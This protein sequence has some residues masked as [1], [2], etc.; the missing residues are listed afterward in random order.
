MKYIAFDL[1]ASSGKMMLGEFDGEILKTEVLHRFPNQQISANGSLYWNFLGIYQHLTEGLQKGFQKAGGGIAGL[2]MDSFCNDFGL[3]GKNGD[4]L[5]QVH[6]YRDERAQKNQQK[7]YELISKEELHRLTGNQNA[8]FNTV[9]QL[10]AMRIQ[11]DGFL[12]D[13]CDVLLHIPDLLC[14][15]LTGEKKSEY[16]ISSVTQ[17]FDYLSNT[18]HEGILK[19][20]GIPSRIFAP[21]VDSGTVVGNIT[22]NVRRNL[23]IGNLDVIAVAEHDTAS[24]VAALPGF[25]ENPA[26]ISSGTWSLMGVETSEVITNPKTF[27][28]NIAFEGGVE[29]RYRMLKNIMG[30]WLI[31][32]C[33]REYQSMGRNYSFGDLAQLAEKE[34]PF[35]SLI[36]PDYEDFYAPGNMLEKIQ[37]FCEKT[38]QPL[39]E[40]PGQFIRAIEESLALKYRW[41][42]EILEDITGKNIG[43]IHILGGGGQDRI[44]NQFTANACAKPVYVGPT[45]A[46]LTGNFLMQMK[47]RGEIADIFQGRDIVSRSFEIER[48]EPVD[49]TIWEEKYQYM[50]SLIKV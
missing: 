32:E 31:Q 22:E 24:A 43:C 14:Y 26:Y 19:R 44:L 20:F 2:G 10:A 13:E 23:G 25:G 38:A 7:I 12:L 18:W 37:S 21:I 49:I 41:V 4:I 3:V 34:Q 5:N 45:E 9:I 35:R 47:A 48:Y 6:C 1:G 50:K 46:A 30:L 11:G 8:L 40:T 36:D 33:R 27:K 29:H 42:L 28:Y 16:T 39:P 17:M 15:M